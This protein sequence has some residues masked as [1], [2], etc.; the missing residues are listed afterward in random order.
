[1]KVLHFIRRHHHRQY[2]SVAGHLDQTAGL[3]H[4]SI[5]QCAK[6]R[7]SWLVACFYFSMSIIIVFHLKFPVFKKQN[8]SKDLIQNVWSIK[9]SALEFFVFSVSIVKLKLI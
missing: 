4:Y 2:I 1:L 8:V 9:S 3:L 5:S 7:I 6:T